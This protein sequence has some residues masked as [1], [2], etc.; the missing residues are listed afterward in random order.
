MVLQSLQ[1]LGAEVEGPTTAEFNGIR[2]LEMW[3]RVAWSPLWALTLDDL[4]T[5]L[6]VVHIGRCG[7]GGRGRRGLERSPSLAQ[8]QQPSS[9]CI[10]TAHTHP[11]PVPP[12]PCPPRSD[13]ALVVRAPDARLSSL[14]LQRGALVVEGPPGAVI[15]ISGLVVE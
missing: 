10:P 7:R 6:G 15:D 8:R 11:E 1:L 5:K 4:E 3:P 13:A 2:G 9:S 12:P 14:D